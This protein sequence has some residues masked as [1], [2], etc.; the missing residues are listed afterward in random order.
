[1]IIYMCVYLCVYIYIYT[2]STHTYKHA[3]AHF[4]LLSLKYFDHAADVIAT[5]KILGKIR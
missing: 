4:L 2:H 1:M 5:M 3:R